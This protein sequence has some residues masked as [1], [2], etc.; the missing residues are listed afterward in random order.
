MPRH[1]RWVRRF[2][3]LK[4]GVALLVVLCCWQRAAAQLTITSN[5]FDAFA[6]AVA[7]AAPG[8]V[9]DF[10]LGADSTIHF[11]HAITLSSD[12]T[13]NGNSAVVFDGGDSTDLFHVNSAVTANFSGLTFQHGLAINAGGAIYSGFGQTNITNSS[14]FYNH[15]NNVGGAVYGNL[16]ISGS[17][18]AYNDAGNTGGAVSAGGSSV[19]IV[20]DN[21]T[22]FG[23][24]AFNTGGAI[25]GG[26]E[27]VVLRNST[28]FGN[29]SEAFGGGGVGM[30]ERGTFVIQSSI[31]AG[32]YSSNFGGFPDDVNAAG[33]YSIDHSLIGSPIQNNLV[34][35]VDGNLVGDGNNVAGFPIA[36]LL[37]S[38]A[39]Y[40]GPTETMALLGL[41]NPALDAGTSPVGLLYD[42][43]GPG[44]QR[45][46]GLAA[47]IGAF[48]Q[49]GSGTVVLHAG[50]LGFG[51]AGRACG[52]SEAE[53][54]MVYG[55]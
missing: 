55:W 42:Q 54:L 30:D 35:G 32:N 51:W 50:R 17:T 34:N 16:H 14:F 2:V 7:A 49:P 53:G 23:N 20:V 28:V 47:D 22:F 11:T 38:L 27:T 5:D 44:Y 13:F 40:G 52:K 43:R 45:V 6:A 37:G 36:G 31:I 3:G 41:D 15:S 12:I 18:F 19:N 4:S 26:T 10:N 48:E 33:T 25:D 29:S 21:S 24:L 46:S 9:V 1:E 8:T 39:H